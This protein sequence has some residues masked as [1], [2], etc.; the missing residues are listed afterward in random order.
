MRIERIGAGDTGA[1]EAISRLFEAELAENG[2]PVDALAAHARS[3]GWMVA[4]AV[5]ENGALAGAIIACT[6]DPATARYYAP[7]G[8]A[9]LELFDRGD[10]DPGR[11]AGVGSLRD[12]AVVP[13]ARGQGVGRT[14]AEAALRFLTDAGCARAVTLSWVHGGP[15]PSRPLFERLGFTS[16]GEAREFYLEQS[17]REGWRCRSCAGACRCSAILF[18]R[19]L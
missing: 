13:D 17:L 18:V 14:L 7:F 2:F 1:L 12:L 9:A 3:V 11:G 8:A 19:E 5:Q 4:A 6:V 10:G 15:H 16:L